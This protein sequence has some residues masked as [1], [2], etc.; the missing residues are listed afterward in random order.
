MG[1]RVGP[2][3]VWTKWRREKSHPYRV[4]NSKPSTVQLVASLYTHCASTIND[5]NF[6]RI[7]ESTYNF[8]IDSKP[9]EGPYTY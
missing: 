3:T 2:E 6:S 7:L 8:V 9:F 5:T 1:G 4:S